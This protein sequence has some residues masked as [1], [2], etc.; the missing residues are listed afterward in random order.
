MQHKIEKEIDGK[1]AM[2]IWDRQPL[3]KN[4]DRYCSGGCMNEVK[5]RGL[6]GKEEAITKQLSAI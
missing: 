1:F 5:K 6:Y 3:A 2:C 4:L